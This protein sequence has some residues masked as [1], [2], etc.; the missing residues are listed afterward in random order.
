MQGL[1]FREDYRGE[2]EIYSAELQQ[3]WQR[4]AHNSIVG[5]RVQYG[6][7]ENRNL[8][9]FPSAHGSQFT[10]PAADQDLSSPFRR[11]SFYGYHQWQVLDSLQLIGGLTYDWLAY[12][13]NFRTAP[14][15]EEETQTDGLSPKAGMIWSPARVWKYRK[16]NEIRLI[17]HFGKALR[18][19]PGVGT[20]LGDEGA[21]VGILNAQPCL[22]NTLDSALISIAAEWI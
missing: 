22:R 3:L 5:S 21:R 8:Q 6:S 15:S 13:E 18:R 14:L 1:T 7:F 4:P 17:L 19:T 2:L 11:I 16:S 9:N 12:P 10:E 20:V